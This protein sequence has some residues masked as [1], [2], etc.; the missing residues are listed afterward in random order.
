MKLLVGHAYL[1]QKKI[2]V[3]IKKLEGKCVVLQ[4]QADS[5][6]KMAEN[7]NN[8]LKELGD[9]EN[10]NLAIENDIEIVLNTLKNAHH[11]LTNIRMD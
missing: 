4:K 7:F 9:I 11:D 3:E 5:W 8:T 6:S 10:F 1:N 2:D